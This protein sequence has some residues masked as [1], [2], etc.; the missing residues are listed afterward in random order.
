MWGFRGRQ[1]RASISALILRLCK[2]IPKP[3][4][5]VFP[6]HWDVFV[7]ESLG[8]HARNGP[9][10]ADTNR[11]TCSGLSVYANST[12]VDLHHFRVMRYMSDYGIC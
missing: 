9:C 12:Q 1:R 4:T 10:G 8:R 7:V 5:S 6:G 11:W 2:A 3:S